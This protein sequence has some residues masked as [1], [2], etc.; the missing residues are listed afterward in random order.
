MV[1]NWSFLGCEGGRTVTMPAKERQHGLYALVT[2][3]YNEG[4]LIE[5]TICSVIAQRCRPAKWII[6]S[7]GSTDATDAIATRYA[8]EYPFI[9]LH[10]LTA[11]HPRNFAAQ[12]HAINCGLAQLTP[13]KFDF[14]GNLDADITMAPE[15]FEVLL[16]KFYDDPKLGLAGGLI[17]ERGADGVFRSRRDNSLTSVAHAVQLFRLACFQAIGEKY[18]LLPFGGPDTYAEVTARMRGWRVASF[19]DLQALHHRTT[20]SAGGLLRGY[21]RQGLMD[22]SLGTLP[23]F[24]ILKVLRRLNTRPFVIGSA[25]RLA[26]F[27]SSY[28]RGYKRPVPNEFVGYFRGEQRAR[29]LRLFRGTSNRRFPLGPVLPEHTGDPEFK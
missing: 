13:N 26:G 29:L 27:V 11:D 8:A 22:H 25:T 24:E 18:M 20:G 1:S 28:C 4:T 5:N 21:F 9:E 15:Y 19:S 6:V 14:I 23:V 7:D 2:A 3:A 10:R 16:Q 12:A 17:H